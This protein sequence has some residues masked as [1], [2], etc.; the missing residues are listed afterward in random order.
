MK[1]TLFTLFLLLLAVETFAH[2][3]VVDGIYYNKLS[4][5][6]SV[7]VTFEGADAS[8]YPNEYTGSVTIPDKVT[9]DGVT[10]SVISIGQN[11]FSSCTGLT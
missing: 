10:Y 5:G 11:R 2:D 7:A 8:S 4:D 3:F 9:Y 1:K 6:A